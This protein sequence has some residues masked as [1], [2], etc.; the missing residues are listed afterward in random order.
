MSDD[1]AGS[2]EVRSYR[3]VFQLERRVY[4]IDR[5]RLP[6]GGIPVRG[7]V[8]CIMLVLAASV[9]STLPLVGALASVL[10]WYLRDVAVPV[11]LAALLAI[12]RVEGR[13][14]HLAVRSLLRQRAEPRWWSG[15]RP[16][17]APG[18]VWRPDDLW[19]LP[20]GSDGRWRSFAFTGPG[21]V[22][23]S[24]PHECR[25]RR[26]GYLAALLR[27]PHVTLTPL[28]LE[29]LTGGRRVLS[30]GAGARLRVR[31][32]DRGSHRSRRGRV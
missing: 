18:A 11:A 6:P 8:Y 30:L 27:R 2:L 16:A 1:G 24:G 4:R 20:D 29:G 9:T 10:P 13:P 25:E 12:V 15:L 7:A 21:A 31:S 23:F 3:T 19:M 17:T 28:E 14:F 26:G 32:G 22:M 5:L